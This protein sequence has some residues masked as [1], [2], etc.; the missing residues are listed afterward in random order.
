MTD[1]SLDL[2]PPNKTKEPKAPKAKKEPKA[3][4]EPKDPN[5]PAK[6]RGPR[7][8]YGYSADSTIVIVKDKEN[9]YRGA[10]KAW[11]DSI[12]GFDGQLVKSWE[13]SRKAEKDPPRGWLRFFVQDGTVSLNRPATPAAAEAAPAETPAV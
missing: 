9:K 10:R 12:V 5:A 1:A 11:F 3:P 6:P 4:K 8:D 13:E 2:T 7:Q